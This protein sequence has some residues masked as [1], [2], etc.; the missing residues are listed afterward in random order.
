M[1]LSS[2]CQNDSIKLMQQHQTAGFEK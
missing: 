1:Y 2:Q